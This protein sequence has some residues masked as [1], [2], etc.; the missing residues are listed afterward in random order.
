MGRIVYRVEPTPENNYM[1]GMGIEFT[2]MD[3]ET[4]HTLEQYVEG[5]LFHE[6][7]ARQSSRNTLNTDHLRKH[8]GEPVLQLTPAGYA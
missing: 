3:A 8:S 4:M 1:Q 7:N 2:E 6:L 5:L